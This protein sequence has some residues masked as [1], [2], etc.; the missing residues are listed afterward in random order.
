VVNNLH[1]ILAKVLDRSRNHVLDLEMNCVTYRHNNTVEVS[2]LRVTPATVDE[3]SNV[4]AKSLIELLRE[5]PY[6]F[7]IICKAKS[8]AATVICCAPEIIKENQPIWSQYKIVRGP[9]CGS[10]DCFDR[11][12]AKL[13]EY[14]KFLG[15]QKTGPINWFCEQCKKTGPW[16]KC[17]KCKYARYCSEDCQKLHWPTHK[18]KCKKLLS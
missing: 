13:I 11:C 14:S 18:E 10:K 1:A 6:R 8:K 3:I 5:G 16:K 9:I 12:R 2:T 17:S 15:I 7:C 4:A